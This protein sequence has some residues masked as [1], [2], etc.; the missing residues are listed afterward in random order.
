M[1]HKETF[2]NSLDRLIFPHI[3]MLTCHPEA[4]VTSSTDDAEDIVDFSWESYAGGISVHFNGA[5]RGSYTRVTWEGKTVYQRENGRTATCKP[6]PWVLAL[7]E[8]A[9]EQRG[10]SETE[11]LN[12]AFSA[13]WDSAGQFTPV[14]SGQ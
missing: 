10:V 8:K 14:E 9:A 6:G 2:A 13:A 4:R 11:E 1:T 7:Y 3:D 5:N 12:D